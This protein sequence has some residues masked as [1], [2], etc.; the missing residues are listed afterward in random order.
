MDIAKPIAN[1][2]AALLSELSSLGVQVT[3]SEYSATAFGDYSVDFLAGKRRFRL[4]RDRSQYMIDGDF[5]ELKNAGLWRAFDN[6]KDLED[7]VLSWLR[8]V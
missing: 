7:A 1:D 2:L 5:A 6:K 8:G 4:V 3:G